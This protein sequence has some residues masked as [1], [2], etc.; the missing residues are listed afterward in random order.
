M[1]DRAES[2]LLLGDVQPLGQR[3]QRRISAGAG[4][5]GGHVAGVFA[6]ARIIDEKKRIAVVGIAAEDRCP[7]QR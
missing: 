7:I 2:E 3:A 6:V 4:A 1:P 5:I